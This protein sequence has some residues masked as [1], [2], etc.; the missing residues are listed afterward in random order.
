MA[1]FSAQ[2]IA[3]LDVESF[4]ADSAACSFIDGGST[5]PATPIYAQ[6]VWSTGLG[7][8]CSWVGALDSSPAP[9]TTTPNWTGAAI[10]YNVTSGRLN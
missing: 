1:D 5:P 3:S 7:V 6:R 2:I 9:T 10:D 8:W 4:V